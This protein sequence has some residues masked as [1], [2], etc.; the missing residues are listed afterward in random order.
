MPL[1]GPVVCEVSTLVRAPQQTAF[2]HVVLLDLP[3]VLRNYGPLPAVV[4][5]D[6]HVGSWNAVGD[7]RRILLSDGT[8]AREELLTFDRPNGFTYRVGELTSS[9]RRLTPGANGRWQFEDAGDGTTRVTWRYAF[10][11]RS[12]VARPVL[13]LLARLLWRGYMRTVL[14]AIREQIERPTAAGA[15]VRG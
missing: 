12:V 11:P 10:E 15:I 8:R 6:E 4:G 7:S 9:M 13:W 1:S 3:S 14:K 5:T 2:E